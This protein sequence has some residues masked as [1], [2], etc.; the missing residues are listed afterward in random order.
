[1]VHGLEFTEHFVKRMRERRFT[2]DEVVACLTLGKKGR[3]RLTSKGAT[4]AYVHEGRK[5]IAQQTGE[6]Q[7]RL[8]TCTK[9]TP[10]ARKGHSHRKTNAHRNAAKEASARKRQRL[11]ELAGEE[12]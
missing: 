5:V 3:E 4:A 1:M 11:E 6:G 12:E 2:A 10:K 9:R 8:V 7:F